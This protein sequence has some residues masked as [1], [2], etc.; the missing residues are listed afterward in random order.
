M[1]LKYIF[2]VVLFGLFMLGAGIA[3]SDYLLTGSVKA[4]GGILVVDGVVGLLAVVL[5]VVFRD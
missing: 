5:W 2:V 3:T 4:V 1:D